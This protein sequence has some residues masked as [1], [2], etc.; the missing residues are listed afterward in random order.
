MARYVLLVDGVARGKVGS[1]DEARAWLRGYQAE[2]AEDDPD[3][4]H[5][6]LRKLSALSW[7]TGGSLVPQEMFIDGPLHSVTR[8]PRSD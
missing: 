3:A 2:H 8:S 7:L 4:T 6:Q 1:D 5:V